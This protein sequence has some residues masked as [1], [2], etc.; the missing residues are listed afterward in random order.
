MIAASLGRCLGQFAKHHH[1]RQRRQAAM[2][3]Q[4]A[5]PTDRLDQFSLQMEGQA[6][7][8][9]DM[10]VA[11][12]ELVAVMA[13]QEGSGDQLMALAAGVIAEAALPDIGQAVAAM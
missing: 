7:V 3:P 12:L 4:P 5:M 11:A 8:A 10:L 1:F 9:A 2:L 6:F 13:E